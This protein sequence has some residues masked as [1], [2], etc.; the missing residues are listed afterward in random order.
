ML[1][2]PLINEM[3]QGRQG[4]PQLGR[5]VK[6]RKG[7]VWTPLSY[8]LVLACFGHHMFWQYHMEASGGAVLRCK[9]RKTNL[10]TLKVPT[11]G[12]W[13]TRTMAVQQL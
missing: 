8:L 11:T 3:Q 12:G 7:L 2:F 5:E 10:P 13:Y 1:V 9:I 4:F 6:T